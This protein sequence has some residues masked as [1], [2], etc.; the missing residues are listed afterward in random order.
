M[1]ST[2]EKHDPASSNSSVPDVDTKSPIAAGRQTEAGQ[3]DA[4]R[5]DVEVELLGRKLGTA[6]LSG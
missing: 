4:R 5:D 6:Q 2:L 3:V 1:S